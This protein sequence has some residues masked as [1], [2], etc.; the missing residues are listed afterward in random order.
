MMNGIMK[1]VLAAILLLL[2]ASAACCQE[3]DD[4]SLSHIR[5]QIKEIDDLLLQI[6]ETPP[7]VERSPYGPGNFERFIEVGG[8]ERRYEIHVPPGYS[9][10]RAW[11]AVINFHGGGGR[12]AAARIQSGMDATADREGF[13]VI[14]PDGTGLF[15]KRLLTWNA[16]DC[17]SYAVNHK[18]DDI[19]FT[20]ALLDDVVKL[21]HIDQRR[22]YATGMSNGAFMS[23]RVACELSDRIAAIGPVAGVMTV[24]DCRPQR[25]VPIIHFHGTLDRYSPYGGGVGE[26]SFSKVPYRSVAQNTAE[27]L[28]LNH[29][30][31]E[32]KKVEKKSHATIATYAN[33]RGCEV[34]VVSLE[35]MGHNWPGGT[36][37]IPEKYEGELSRD[38][39]AND[40]MWDFFR[41]HPL[42]PGE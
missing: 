31:A 9:K 12:A 2:L 17:C 39:V 11:P 5:Q 23:Y 30:P 37:M 3:D 19:G 1:C 22:I 36:Q 18:I 15:Q 14:Y 32:P 8:R 13:L 10:D 6:K 25:P 38:I 40:L 7:S 24:H 33:D 42:T 26:K 4:F 21:F 41:R 27:W 29:I 35:G 34:M 16:G 28:Q 20:R